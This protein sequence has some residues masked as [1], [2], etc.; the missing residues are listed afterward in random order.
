M[1]RAR[2]AGI[3]ADGLWIVMLAGCSSWQRGPAL[4]PTPD[5]TRRQV[6]AVID[7]LHGMNADPRSTWGPDQTRLRLTLRDGSRVEIVAPTLDGDSLVGIETSPYG[8]RSIPLAQLEGIQ[9]YQGGGAGRP[10]A[11][12]VGM[13]AVLVGVAWFVQAVMPCVG[14]C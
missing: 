12:G 3:V 1:L 7:L 14:P 4:G 2:W 8:R 5:D 10:V 13:I 9:V 11:V 6:Q